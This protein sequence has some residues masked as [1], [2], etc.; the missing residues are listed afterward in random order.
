MGYFLLGVIVG[1]VIE[2][3]LYQFWW[4]PNHPETGKLTGGDF[5]AERKKLTDKI[6]DKDSEI[7]HLK[8]RIATLG[9]QANKSKTAA[10]K[11]KPASKPAARPATK[12]P[13]SPKPAAK[14]PASPKPKASSKPD[15]LRKVS[16]IGPKIAELL[17]A[18]GIDSFASLAKADL[19]RIQSILKDAGPRYALADASSW[20]EQAQLLDEG[21]LD[22][23][24]LLQASL[25][26]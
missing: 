6:T 15:D 3:L 4:K 8:A 13:A 22:A 12:K 26:K 17:K 7:S 1:W 2:W 11:P 21:K 19:T 14:K 18:D 25:K 16:G 10:V 24:E 9:E 23:L 5:S 20:S